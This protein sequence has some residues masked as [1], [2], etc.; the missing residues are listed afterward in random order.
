MDEFHSSVRGSNGQTSLESAQGNSSLN[1]IQP[2]EIPEINLPKG[3]GALKGIDE[4]F[5]VNPV[6]G[7][8]GLSLPLPITPSRNGF[9]PALSLSYNSG[10]GNSTFGLGW[11]LNFP[12]I[13]RKTDHQL[14]QYRDA[15]GS[16]TFVFSGSEDLVPV[17]EEDG[18]DWIPV[19]DDTGSLLIEQFRPRLEGGF[20]RIERITPHGGNQ[21]WWKVTTRDNVTTLYGFSGNNRISDPEDPNRIFTWLPEFSYDDKGNW[22]QYAFKAE[23]LEEVQWAPHENNRIASNAPFTNAYLKTVRYGNRLPFV[24]SDPYQPLLPTPQESTFFQLV[25]DYGEHDLDIPTPGEVQPWPAREDAFSSYRSGF[26][27]RTYRLCQRILLF[28]QFDA[29]GQTP[30]LVRSLDISYSP[31]SINGS[32][33]AEVTYLTAA[34]ETGY[35][36]RQDNSYSSRSQPPV[37]FSYQEVAWNTEI[38]TVNPGSLVHAPTG[39]TKGYRWTDLYSEGISGILSE[40]PGGWYFKE[41]MGLVN[42]NLQFSPARIVAKRPSYSGLEEGT[43]SLQDL[44]ANGTKQLVVHS[45]DQS[46]YFEFG[47][48]GSP[49]PFVAFPSVPKVDLRDPNLRMIDLN[50]DGRAEMVMSEESVFV[51]YE[52]QG[53]K[54]FSS[55]IHSLKT[56]DEETGPAMIFSDPDEREAILLADLSG[57]GLSDIIRVRNGEVC[58][59]PNRGYGRFGAKIS[60]SNAPLFDLQNDFKPSRLVLADLSGTGTNDLLYYSTDGIKIYLNLSGNAWSDPVSLGHLLPLNS[61]TELTI[62]DL[63]GTGT[64][65]LV[66]SSDLPAQSPQPFRYLDLM[67]SAKPHLM[68]GISNNMGKHTTIEYK[69]STFY[70]LQD[71]LAGEEWATKLPFPV[72]VISR[73]TK[74]DR[75]SELRFS[76]EYR[77]SH[78]YY[79]PDEREFRGFGRI[80]QLDT[81]QYEEWAVNNA[82]THLEQD[83]AFFQPPVLT[84]SWYHTGAFLDRQNI[85][86]QFSREYW[87]ELFVR[88]FP[89]EPLTLNEPQLPD[90][91]IVSAPHLTNQSLGSELSTLEWKEALRACK[92]MLLRQEV[93]AL[94][95]NE[96]DPD[97][98]VR[99][100][101]PYG[102]VTHNCQIHVHQP[103]SGNQHAVFTL[104]ELESISIQYERDESDPRIGHN[105]NLS[106]DE[107]GHVL[108][109]ASIVYPRQIV[110][111]DLPLDVQDKQA[112]THIQYQQTSYSNDVITDQTYRLRAVVEQRGYEITGLTPSGDWFQASD[113]SDLLGMGSTGIAFETAPSQGQVQRRLIHHTRSLFFNETLD[114][115]LPQGQINSLGLPYE[116][117]QLIYTDSLVQDIYGGKIPDVSLLM[118]EGNYDQDGTTWWGR[119]GTVQLID[120]GAG[121]TIADARARFFVPLSFT[122]PSGATTTVSY[123]PDAFLLVEGATDPLGNQQVIEAFN[124]RTLSPTRMRDINDNIS[125]VILDELGLVKAMALMGKGGEADNLTGISEIT[126]QAER[127]LIDTYFTLTDTNTLRNTASQLLQGATARFVYDLDAYEISRADQ[128]EALEI[129]PQLS[130]CALPPLIP[131]ASGM[132]VRE[133]HFPATTLQLSFAYSDGFGNVIMSKTQAEP[134]EALEFTLQPDC[135]FQLQTIDTSLSGQLRWIGNGRTI[136]NNKGKPVKVYEPFFSVTPHFENG[137]GLVERGVTPLNYY[138]AVGRLIRAVNPDGTERRSE[139]GPWG[140]TIFDANDTVQD[141]EW[142]LDRG[143]PDPNGPAP[144]N[145]PSLAAWKSA[146]HHG[147]SLTVHHDS[148]GRSIYSLSHNR[149]DGVDEF[150]STEIDLNIQGQPIRVVDARNNEVMAFRYNIAG[151]KV[152]ELSSESG[153]RWEFSNAQGQS[154]R[155]WDSRDQQFRMVYDELQRR[156]HLFVRE[157]LQPEI[158]LERSVYGE[159]HPQAIQLNLRG[160]LIEQYDGAGSMAIIQRDFKGNTLESNRRLAV[161]YRVAVDWSPLLGLN[162]L[163]QIAN[164]A[165]PLLEGESFVNGARFDALNRQVEIEHSD[166]STTFIQFNEAGLLGQVSIQLSG[167]MSPTTFISDIDYNARGQRTRILYQT[168]PGHQYSTQLSYHPENYRLSQFTTRRHS[169]NHLLQDL[170][171]TYDAVGNITAIQDA[172]QSSVI[173]SNIQVDAHQSFTYDALNR[174]IRAEGREHAAQNNLQPNENGF[175]PITEVPFLNSPE[176]LQRYVQEFTYDAADNLISMQHN[177]GNVLRW[178]RH[179]QYAANNNQLTGTSLPGD[180]EGQFSAGYTYDNHGNMTSMPHLPLMQWDQFNRLKASS[181]QVVNNGTPE[182]TYYVYDGAGQRIRKVTD[183]QAGQGQDPTRREERIY[184]GPY[185]RYREFANDGTTVELERESLFLLD[186]QGRIGRIDRLL[187]G[188]DG[189]PAETRRFFLSNHLGSAVMEVDEQVNVI[190]YEEYH[191]YGTTAYRAGTSQLEVSRNRYR[192]TGKEL[193]GE[194]G[195]SFHGA[196]YYASWLGRWTAADPI[197]LGDGPN[198]YGYVHGNPVR[199]V[200]PSGTKGKVFHEGAIISAEEFESV[201][202]K[203]DNLAPGTIAMKLNGGQGEHIIMPTRV[204]EYDPHNQEGADSDHVVLNIKS[205]EWRKKHV[206]A[207]IKVEEKRR[208]ELAAKRILASN[209]MIAAVAI[210]GTV[211]A[212]T[213]GAAAAIGATTTAGVIAVGAAEG[214]VSSG[215]TSGALTW[216]DGGSGRDIARNALIDGSIGAVGG[217]LFGA[218]GAGIKNLRGPSYRTLSEARRGLELPPIER[219]RRTRGLHT[220][221]DGDMVNVQ[222]PPDSSSIQRASHTGNRYSEI[223]GGHGYEVQGKTFTV[224]EGT[225]IEFST[226]SGTT[227]DDFRAFNI[228]ETGINPGH[229]EIYGP[230][231]EVPEHILT[232]RGVGAEELQVGGAASMVD[233]PT[234]LSDLIEP[235][236]GLV[237]FNACRIHIP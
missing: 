34:T 126:D 122:D 135:Q 5:R 141:S 196:R 54:G 194:T 179:Y 110:D 75:I 181:R 152:Y 82:G 128:V 99:E 19:T 44:G 223:W 106:F 151:Q 186:D 197:G 125:E 74:E 185:E 43:V 127:D 205:Y 213:G 67:S 22:V 117:Y 162:D 60:M 192:Y 217:G 15:E 200:D 41:N 173:F 37:E 4:K 116:A 23:N 100:A 56:F 30:C 69:S 154:I 91:R 211:T 142:Y 68:T 212:V 115:P 216:L 105:L 83:E 180:L 175:L 28:H 47:R 182:T 150:Y 85:L 27:I 156:T 35:I 71:K 13:Q 136:L 224:P 81:E 46:G 218:F 48:D 193:D 53:K 231:M 3:G 157:G 38:Q 8:A 52:N 166:Q 132:I 204:L 171:Y 14:P 87:T 18:E 107:F 51:W 208:N 31:S 183:R 11:S 159:I 153:E 148:L 73:I 109:S 163:T 98:M 70:Y 49:L 178:T 145:L 78:G 237:L 146:Q 64:P 40:H 24:P 230:G 215:V 138:D 190:T 86:D 133:D 16:D 33:E 137:K 160:T 143:S 195:L 209:K 131:Q 10:T 50:G 20:A 112:T 165:N 222:S 29:L 201:V 147:T 94:D 139:F 58:Y 206:M 164:A 102:V 77:Y 177:G 225:Y 55:A 17:L 26:E 88:R 25:F 168:S 72:H 123:H 76:T 113:L 184:F 79:D 129:D 161:E 101:K 114:A 7:T 97:T 229:R 111:P 21:S 84:R 62:T 227:L 108:E 57:D 199:L 236:G 207:S 172:S 89:E 176:A 42:G 119:S 140:K 198:R 158:L 124:F 235:N 203:E 32:G 104:H 65:C 221:A 233:A 228:E 61:T 144:A 6:N 2:I 93:F 92:G 1:G 59:W 96:A 12:V 210:T 90:A 39:L 134:G 232:H 189:G 130:E 226:P 219:V 234:Y 63:L 155:R 169:D 36:R 95:G 167:E 188:N 9:A 118:G 80:D 191:P 66:W 103:R 214:L 220:S 149:V 120:P 202:N 121:E 170:S 45:P 174:L 187:V